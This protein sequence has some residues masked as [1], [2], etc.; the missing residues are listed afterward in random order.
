[1]PRSQRSVNQRLVSRLRRSLS[2]IPRT[3]L[4]CLQALVLSGFALLASSH[5]LHVSTPTTPRCAENIRFVLATHLLLS[6]C[7]HSAAVHSRAVR[8]N[9]GARVQQAEQA[10]D[11]QIPAVSQ[12]PTL[13]SSRLPVYRDVSP[14]SWHL[15]CA[16]LVFAC[17]VCE[18]P[19]CLRVA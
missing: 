16:G 7:L 9:V 3:S 12:I 19:S 13:L 14:A 6:L 18:L 1:L 8:F 17:D 4:V 15:C 10:R 11:L 2:T 5:P